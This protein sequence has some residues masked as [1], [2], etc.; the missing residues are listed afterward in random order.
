MPRCYSS[1][2][3]VTEKGSTSALKY[4][5][6]RERV[7]P[8]SQSNEPDSATQSARMFSITSS[9]AAY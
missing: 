5:N 3:I 8:E 9:M 2:L 6:R 4:A 7:M 1:G